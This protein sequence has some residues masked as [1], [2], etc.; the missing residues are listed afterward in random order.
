MKHISIIVPNGQNNLSSIVGPYK[1]FSRANTYWNEK[2][3]RELFRIELVGISK[4]VNFYEGLF[5]V[6][7]QRNLSEITKTDRT[8]IASLNHNV[9]Q[10]I[11]ENQ[12]LVDWLT[13]LYKNGAEVSSICTGAF[14]LAA[15]GLQD[16]KNCFTNC[17]VEESFRKM[18]LKV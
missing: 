18:F 12:L 1:I 8:M 5:S 17:A 9:E 6:K 7:P 14:L 13:K 16:G 15:S 3:G 11:S 4:E 10:A 2:E